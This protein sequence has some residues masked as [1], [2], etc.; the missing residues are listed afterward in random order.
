MNAVWLNSTVL[1]LYGIVYTMTS[2]LE[3]RATYLITAA[4]PSIANI[5]ALQQA[6]NQPMAILYTSVV[7]QI[8]LSQQGILISYLK[9]RMRVCA[10]WHSPETNFTRSAHEPYP[11]HGSE[12]HILTHFS[13]NKM[14]AILQTAFWNAFSWMKSFVSRFLRVQMTITQHWFR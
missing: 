10:L 7:I 11:K 3:H 13:L 1:P 2:L 9:K 5:T 8:L 6:I 14:A 4:V 12:D